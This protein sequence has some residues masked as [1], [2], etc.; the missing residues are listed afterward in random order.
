MTKANLAAMTIQ[1]L[2]ALNSEVVRMIK[3]KRSQA[4][5]TAVYQFQ[6]G[7]QVSFT[8]K[9]GVPITGI[10]REVKRTK[11]AVNCGVAG[12]WLVAASMLSKINAK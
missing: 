2:M 12:N 5:S 8:G 6:A 1:D 7:D 10:I 9:S 11:V 3:A 4:N